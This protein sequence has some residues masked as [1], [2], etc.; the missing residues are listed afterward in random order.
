MADQT[1][2]GKEMIM[3]GTGYVAARSG[4][5][6]LLTHPL[7]M[8]TV[9]AVAGYYGYKYRKE[10]A[11]AVARASDMGKDFVLDQKEKLT[12][13]LEEEREAED[14]AASSAPTER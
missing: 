12:D 14:E 11:T 13:I 1:Q 2:M 4:V 7:V 10:I 5:G 8:L 3:A 9:G 6:R